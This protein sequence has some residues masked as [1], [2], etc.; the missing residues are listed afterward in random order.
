MVLKVFWLP[1]LCQLVL[2]P[3]TCRIVAAVVKMGQ[4]VFSGSKMWQRLLKC[5]SICYTEILPQLIHLFCI[6]YL[7]HPLY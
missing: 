3:G 1:F 4:R 6:L 5:D 2:Y 7:I